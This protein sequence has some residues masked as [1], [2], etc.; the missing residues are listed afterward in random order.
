MNEIA[1]TVHDGGKQGWLLDSGASSH[2]TPIKKDF[3]EYRELKDPIEVRV[4]DGAKLEAIGKV[5]VVFR[6]ND[7]TML[8]VQEVLH[9]P[10]LDRRLLSVPKIAQH[11]L[12]MRFGA[13]YCGIF[14]GNDLIISAK[15]EGNIYTLNVEQE[16]VMVAE[17]KKAED[18]WE[19]WHDRMGHPSYN[20][21]Q[22]TKLVTEGL[23]KFNE[24][25]DNLCSGCLQGKMAV[26]AFPKESIART[27]Y[28]LQ[29]VHSDVMG[30]MEI[31]TPGGCRFTLSF[32]DDFSTYVNVYFL[33]SNSEVNTKF[34]EYK[35]EMELQC[36]TKITSICTDNGSEFQNQIFDAFCRMDGI[37]HQKTVPYSP[38]QNGVVERMN[39]TI[40]EKA[41]SMMHY[42][43]VSQTWWAEAVNTSVHLINR[44]TTSTHKTMTPFGMCFKTKPNLHYLR[45]FGSL[46]YA[47][48]SETKRTKFGAKSSRCMLL[49]YASHTKRYKVLDLEVN[50]VKVSRAI[51][52]DER[53]VDSI[54]EN[55]MLNDGV[56][57]PTAQPYVCDA[58]YESRGDLHYH[59]NN[60]VDIINGSDDVDM[61]GQSGVDDVDMDAP[62]R[63]I[64]SEHGFRPEEIAS[65]GGPADAL[66]FH[67]S[68][69][70]RSPPVMDGRLLPDKTSRSASAEV[71]RIEPSS[72]LRIEAERADNNSENSIVLYD[73][74]FHSSASDGEEPPPRRS[75]LNRDVSLMVEVAMVT[76]HLTSSFEEA[77]NG[78]EKDQ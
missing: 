66:V 74:S 36:G 32:I 37:I 24:K 49:G 69:T 70:R 61:E 22:K 1:F 42:K 71:A 29:L 27:N 44:T 54:Y 73:P 17:H 12:N 63:A 4:A 64:E 19:L 65:G 46:G 55:I 52:L 2:M 31:K 30:P 3:I 48:V 38:Q 76:Q 57:K 35:N 33:K 11:G 59:G 47:H 13:K 41:R 77:T 26:A 28:P 6:C 68:M 10:A 72:T 8:T 50:T 39:R 56:H 60:D 5:R 16:H 62:M 78:Y 40:T 14:R 53:E 20:V 45:V 21:Y 34:I 15:R 18:R 43:C 7:G 75:R 67:P 25:S 9:I 51:T 23:P 58:D